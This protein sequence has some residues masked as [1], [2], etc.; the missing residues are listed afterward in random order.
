MKGKIHQ[1][2]EK[3]KSLRSRNINSQAPHPISSF[4]E[5]LELHL[6]LIL[7]LHYSISFSLMFIVHY[8]LLLIGGHVPFLLLFVS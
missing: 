7:S 4:S 1:L 3:V 2:P 8:L 6:L 5:F